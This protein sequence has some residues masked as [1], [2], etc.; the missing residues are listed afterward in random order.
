MSDEIKGLNEECGLFGVWDDDHA[1]DITYLGLHI[2]QHR[3]QEGAG[4]V[5]LTD[6]GMVRHRGLGL[7]AEVFTKPQQLASLRGRAALGHVRYSTAGGRVLENIQPLLFRFTT[8]GDVALAHNGNL[9]NARSLRAQLEEGGAIFQSSSDTEVLMHLIRRSHQTTFVAQLKDALNQV[10]GGFAFMLLTEHGLYAASDPNGFRPL[11]VGTLPDGGTV[12]CSETAALNAVGATFVQDVAPGGLVI[13]DQSGVRFDHYTTHTQLAVCSMEYIY[14]AR[15]DS[16]IHGVNVH[17]ARV[18][19]GR[20]LAQEQPVAA[21]IVCGVPNSSL[22]AAMGYAQESGIPY[23][24][25]LVK[26]QYVARTFIQ[27]TQ[28]LRERSV[29]MKLSAIRPV[30]AGKRVVLVDD[31]LVRGTTARQIVKLLR[32]AG[33]K[34]IHLR[35]SSPPLRFPCFYGI[36]IQST[37]ELMAAN[38][39]VAA[40]RTLLGVD[41]LAFLSVAGLEQSVNLTSTAPHHGLCVA[42]FTG[43]Y[44]TPLDDYDATLRSELAQLYINVGEVSA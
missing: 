29:R 32:D 44:P 33:A 37:H 26:S 39:S 18:R 15:P 24:M 25:G 20:R 2:L 1:A 14:F 23:E 38:H 7:L 34:S 43:E 10:H 19:M 40:M 30:V 35:I 8:T 36:D 16:E 41:S 3:G 13:V 27:P 5:G 12:I 42:Y 17:Q 21:D 6:A 31:S 22:S 11:V 28:A 4:I 9:T